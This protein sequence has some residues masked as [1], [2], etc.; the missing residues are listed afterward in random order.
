MPQ[1]ND[2]VILKSTRPIYLKTTAMTRY[3][4]TTSID[5]VRHGEKDS[6]GE[7]TT[8]GHR[9]AALKALVLESL[10]GNI[11][12]YHS[13]AQRVLRTV[14]MIKQLIKK[15]VSDAR[16]NS[17]ENDITDCIGACSMP[18][19]ET[20]SHTRNELHFLLDPS[21]KGTYFSRWT[22]TPSTQ[23]ALERA[24]DLLN[25][26]DQSPETSIV[27]SPKQMAQRVASLLLEQ[28][29]ASLSTPITEKN[30][31]IN[32]THEPVILSFISYAFSDFQ[33]PA[34]TFMDSLERAIDF[35]EGF[36]IKAYQ[37]EDGQYLLTCSFRNY[38]TTFTLEEL[39]TFVSK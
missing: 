3:H 12:I 19:I 4:L 6:T 13:G 22:E 34:P 27:P 11:H 21:N 33:H 37:T 30:N 9:Q 28:L 36:H 26:G 15:N 38:M 1:N 20:E 39:K 18:D 35:V 2:G 29:E 17:F 25:L 23:E 5:T 31:Y 32:G 16:A 8:E 7:L 10:D 14:T 24:Q